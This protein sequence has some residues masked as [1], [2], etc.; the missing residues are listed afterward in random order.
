MPKKSALAAT[1]FFRLWTA[2]SISLTG[3]QVTTLALPLLAVLTM[4]AGA[5]ETSLLTAAAGAAN[6]VLG[7]S[8]GVW[9]DRYE[10]TLMMHV[11]NLGRLIVLVAV[12]LLAW[13]DAL[14]IWVLALAAFLVGA[15]TLLFD[16][17]MVPYMPRLVGAKNIGPANSWLEGSEAVGDVAGPGIAGTLVQWLSAPVALLVDAATYV[18]SSAALLGMPK[19]HPEKPEGA[20]KE[21]HWDAVVS[22]LK[23]LR[24]DRYQWPLA[25]AS[26]HFNF[27][28]AMFAALYLLYAIREVGMSPFTL[29]AMT[30]LGGAAG[31][32]AAAVNQRVISRLGIG[33]TLVLSYALPGITAIPVGFAHVLDKPVG[34]TLIGISQF[35]W[36][37]GIVVMHVCVN[38]IRQTL[39]PDHLMGRIT[40]S[41]R[42]MSWGVNPLGA[43]VGGAMASTALGLANTL[44]VASVGLITSMLWPLLSQ[45]RKLRTLDQQDP[46]TSAEEPVATE[47]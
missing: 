23:L 22:G 9:A 47:S 28:G 6:L 17:A 46:E 38:T 16:S 32:I 2:E 4:D 26:T 15:F 30:M 33:P 21:R 42:F 20:E 45:V 3:A 11:A 1:G 43:L 13:A 41:V 31:L 44:V 34:L 14:D 39:V 10:R 35:S 5:W 18:V 8:A 36:V 37:F 27:F 25:I 7:L 29:G 24:R 40:A 12:P 19:A